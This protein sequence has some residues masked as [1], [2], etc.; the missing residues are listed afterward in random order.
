M[1]DILDNYRGTRL[2]RNATLLS[3]DFTKILYGKVEIPGAIIELPQANT[4]KVAGDCDCSCA[5][6]CSCDCS[7]NCNC[8]C[9]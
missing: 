4:I 8:N 7:C 6:S 1:T 5:C 2:I 9:G 3:R